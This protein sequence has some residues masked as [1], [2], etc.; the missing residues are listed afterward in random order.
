MANDNNQKQYIKY[1]NTTYEL[2]DGAARARLDALERGAPRAAVTASELAL[3]PNKLYVWPEMAALTLT[4]AAPAD[5]GFAGEYHF[6]FTSGAAAPQFRLPDDVLLPEGF[7]IEANR[8][9]EISILEGCL[10]AQSWAVSA[11]A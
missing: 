4:L 3:E 9:Y 7:A 6:F 1:E 11:H 2:T 8:R 5:D 10:S